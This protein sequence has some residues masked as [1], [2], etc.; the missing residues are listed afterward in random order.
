MDYQI[1]VW[2]R[3]PSDWLWK[4]REKG[5][6]FSICDGQASSPKACRAA[7]KTAIAIRDAQLNANWNK[8][9]V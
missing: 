8:L 3:G 1:K 6:R 2:R 4:V 9:E 5:A 7:A